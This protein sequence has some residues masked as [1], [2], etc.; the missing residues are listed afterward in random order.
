LAIKYLDAGRIRGT[1]AERAALTYDDTPT[2]TQLYESAGWKVKD[3]NAFDADEAN[4]EIDF[5]I[6][7]DNSNNAITYDLGANL[8][9]TWVMRFVLNFST[10]TANTANYLIMGV[11][12]ADSDTA[13][14]GA[15][16]GWCG[17]I[18]NESSLASKKRQGM[19]SATN[20]VLT[21]HQDRNENV[22]FA[23]DEDYYCELSRTGT[24]TGV[25]TTRTGS[26]T[27]NVHNTF[28]YTGGE[29][30]QNLRYVRFS[31]LVDNAGGTD[32][33]V[34]T[35]S[36]ITIDDNAT[37]Y[38]SADHTLTFAS[39][40]GIT[41]GSTYFNVD[42]TIADALYLDPRRSSNNYAQTWNLGSTLSETA[43]VLRFKVNITSVDNSGDTCRVFYGMSDL[44]S[45]SG[46]TGS[47][48][49][50]GTVSY[51]NQYQSQWYRLST[52][53]NSLD[54]GENN[55][56]A[57]TET[58]LYIS[59]ERHSDTLFKIRWTTNSDF[60][61]GSYYDSGVVGREGGSGS[62]SSMDLQYFWVSNINVSGNS[63]A[64]IQGNI[65]YAKIWNGVTSV[66]VTNPNLPNGTIFEETDTR[67]Y[68][69]WDGT[70]TW[71][72][73]ATT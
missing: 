11:T 28:S 35:I 54:V 24:G 55:Q 39:D 46:A 8:S 21:E 52:R 7:R 30:A 56:Y 32:Q 69:M 49:F 50:I 42:S 37:S 22:S 61:G 10:N 66:G 4:S 6:M 34:G 15:Q 5:S 51:T 2:Y 20:G 31:D 72:R 38:S 26:H 1:A 13:G 3:A 64:H 40:I 57:L 71:N 59:I 44:P 9:A 33:Q 23:E 73:V 48:S 18:M 53:G 41:G 14:D 29:N 16:D 25:F 70:D 17:Y 36:A 19:I 43:W 45:S 68:Y 60:T 67:I 12:S 62:T 27:G 65:E 47:H 63:D 58:T